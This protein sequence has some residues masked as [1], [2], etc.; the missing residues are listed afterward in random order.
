MQWIFNILAVCLL[1]EE[2]CDVISSL[3]LIEQLKY[4]PKFC[5]RMT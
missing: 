3:S 2:I 5:L 4:C 1:G